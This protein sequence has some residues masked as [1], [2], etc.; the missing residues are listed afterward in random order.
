MTR[1]VTCCFRICDYSHFSAGL[2]FPVQNPQSARKVEGPELFHII[3]NCMKKWDCTELWLLS[4][5]FIRPDRS[6]TQRCSEAALLNHHSLH[7]SAGLGHF[8]F[9]P[10][11][12]S[13]FLSLFLFFKFLLLIKSLKTLLQYHN[14]LELSYS[15]VNWLILRVIL[16]LSFHWASSDAKG[17]FQLFLHFIF[18]LTCTEY[19]TQFCNFGFKMQISSLLGN[20]IVSITCSELSKAQRVQKSVRK[21]FH[22]I[23]IQHTVLSR[24]CSVSKF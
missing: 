21:F 18:V 13:G 8:P 5:P 9:R 4:P 3:Q 23:Y 24:L 10:L 22:P 14:F 11:L 15:L 7:F 20:L 19:K 12:L 1:K 16:T 6:F 17:F 2:T